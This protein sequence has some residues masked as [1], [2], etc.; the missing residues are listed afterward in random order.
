M[1]VAA[2]HEPLEMTSGPLDY[3]YAGCGDFLMFFYHSLWKL[4]AVHQEFHYGFLV[5]YYKLGMIH[6]GPAT[7]CLGFQVY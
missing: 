7:S 2:V 3:G 4:L 6:D 1:S 5:Y